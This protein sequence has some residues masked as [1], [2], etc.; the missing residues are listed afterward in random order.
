M[1]PLGVLAVQPETK[2]PRQ[3]NPAHFKVL[4]ELRGQVIA[5][6]RHVEA[7]AQRLPGYVAGETALATAGPGQQFG[8]EDLGGALL[9][10]RC[11]V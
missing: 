8:A 9:I 6:S 3:A 5:N 7:A 11:N 10:T 1:C 4:S 2:Q